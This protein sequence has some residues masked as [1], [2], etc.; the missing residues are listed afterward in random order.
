M[1]GNQ[2]GEQRLDA[3]PHVDSILGRRLDS[4]RNEFVAGFRTAGAQFDRCSG[5]CPLNP[6]AVCKEPAV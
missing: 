3:S 4:G 1:S 5:K 6:A 2:P